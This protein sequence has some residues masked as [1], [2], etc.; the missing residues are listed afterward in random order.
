MNKERGRSL[1]AAIHSK[2][3]YTTSVTKNR[4]LS[5][6]TFATYHW[7]LVSVTMNCERCSA[8]CNGCGASWRLKLHD[9]S[10]AVCQQAQS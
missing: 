9:L 10:P 4:N 8:A 3:T 1:E 2:L 5:R 7:M 6:P